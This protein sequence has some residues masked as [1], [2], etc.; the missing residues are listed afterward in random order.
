MRHHFGPG[1]ERVVNCSE[2]D[3]LD[4]EVPHCDAHNMTAGSSREDVFIEKFLSAYEDGA[5]ADA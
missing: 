5:W 4:K 1:G 3:R 2:R